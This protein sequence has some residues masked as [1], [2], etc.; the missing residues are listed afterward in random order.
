MNTLTAMV[1]DPISDHWECPRCGERSSH[2]APLSSLLKTVEC[3][4]VGL[5]VTPGYW[6]VERAKTRTATP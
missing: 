1:K 6:H 4:C 5:G 3:N 2:W